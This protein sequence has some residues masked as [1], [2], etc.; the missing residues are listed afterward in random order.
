MRI[1]NDER[2]D[3]MEKNMQQFSLALGNLKSLA[4]N[5]GAE[6]DRESRQLDIGKATKVQ[7]RLECV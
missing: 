7:H 3:E 1:T 4:D 6:V 2:E 5:M